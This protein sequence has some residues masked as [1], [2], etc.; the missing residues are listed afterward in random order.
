MLVIGTF[1]GTICVTCSFIF[2]L[3]CR[4]LVRPL[5]AINPTPDN[6][7]NHEKRKGKYVRSTPFVHTCL[8]DSNVERCQRTNICISF[9]HAVIT[10]SLA[11]YSFLAYGPDIYRDFINHICWLTFL[12]CSF[13]FGLNFDFSLIRK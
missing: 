3:I 10:G 9:L 1:S 2:F 7:E 4:C 8:T 13:S 12:T 5:T 6:V 11:A